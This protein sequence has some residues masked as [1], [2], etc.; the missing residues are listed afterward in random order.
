MCPVRTAVCCCP[1]LLRRCCCL[2]LLLCG[3]RRHAIKIRPA[4]VLGPHA[5]HAAHVLSRPCP[6]LPCSSRHGRGIWELCPVRAT[7]QLH[8]FVDAAHLLALAPL[9]LRP[10]QALIPLCGCPGQGLVLAPAALPACV[11]LILV[12][13]G[14]HIVVQL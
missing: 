14:Q 6:G 9:A 1:R 5:P 2:L 10:W 7:S 4:V 13:A 11:V 3:R 12:T 8:I